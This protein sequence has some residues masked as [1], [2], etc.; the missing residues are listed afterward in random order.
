M[1][2]PHTLQG[3]PSSQA[4]ANVPS[5]IHSVHTPHT[6]QGFPSSQAAA[7]VPSNIHSV[8]T[9]HTL[10]G[11]PSSQAAASVPS[12]TANDAKRVP[13]MTFTAQQRPCPLLRPLPSKVSQPSAD[14]LLRLQHLTRAQVNQREPIHVIP[15]LERCLL[16]EPNDSFQK[17][18]LCGH[19]QAFSQHNVRSPLQS[20]GSFLAKIPVT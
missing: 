19:V 4:A 5:N 13:C 1:H 9:P 2:T 10:Q 3:P 7:N 12:S 20:P 17:V 11:F 16:E 8:H 18:Y 15:L 6:L 14:K